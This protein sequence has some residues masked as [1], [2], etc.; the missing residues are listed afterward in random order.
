V[1][2]AFSLVGELRR[3]P[4]RRSLQKAFMHSGENGAPSLPA[5]PS[6]LYWSVATQNVSRLRSLSY[7]AG[8]TQ[9]V[10]SLQLR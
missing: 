5:H 6:E 2:G 10:A 1:E 7:H 4:S 9:A 3:T 8:H